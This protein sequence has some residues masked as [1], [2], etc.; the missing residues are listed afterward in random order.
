MLI[1]FSTALSDPKTDP[2]A[3]DHERFLGLISRNIWPIK[4]DFDCGESQPSVSSKFKDAR[5]RAH[6]ASQYAAVLVITNNGEWSEDIAPD[7][8][9][10]A[11]DKE[12]LLTEN[13]LHKVTALVGFDAAQQ[14]KNAA[15]GPEE[16]AFD[17][18]D[19][20]LTYAQARLNE[21]WETRFEEDI[22][23][24]THSTL[25]LSEMQA[26]VEKEGRVPFREERPDLDE[27]CREQRA[28]KRAG[29]LPPEVQTALEAL[30]GWRWVFPYND[31]NY[32]GNQ[33]H[34]AFKNLCLESKTTLLP[35]TTT[36]EDGTNV[37]VWLA[38]RRQ[39]YHA[40]RVPTPT[41]AMLETLPQWTWDHDEWCDRVAF[42]ELRDVLASGSVI[43]D[44][45]GQGLFTLRA[46]KRVL[47]WMHGKH[48]S[49]GLQPLRD[50]PGWRWGDPSS[51]DDLIEK[52]VLATALSRLK[53]SARQML[54]AAKRLV[55]P[56]ENTL[57]DIGKNAGTSREAIRQAE[58]RLLSALQHPHILHRVINT[59]KDLSIDV[60]DI[61]ALR[62]EPDCS[63][64]VTALRAEA[65]P[66]QHYA[67]TVLSRLYG[68]PIS[69]AETHRTR[70]SFS[71][72]EIQETQGTSASKL[73]DLHGTTRA[74]N[75]LISHGIETLEDM[76]ALDMLEVSSWH[77]IG[78]QSVEAIK[79]MR[80][81]A[82]AALGLEETQET[83][84][85][86]FTDL[87]GTTR[88][89]NA[90]ISHGI[91]TLEDMAALDMLEASSWRNIGIQSV[92]SIESMREQARTALALREAQEV[93][94][95][96]PDE[97]TDQHVTTT[98]INSPISHDVDSLE[99]HFSL[100]PET[101]GSDTHGMQTITMW[102]PELSPI[103][104]PTHRPES[105][106]HVSSSTVSPGVT[107]YVGLV[108]VSA[109]ATNLPNTPN[110]R[111]AN[112]KTQV[113]KDV[114]VSLRKNDG[115]FHLKNKGITMLATSVS[116]S[117]DGWE[118][119]LTPSVTQDS[120]GI[121]DGGHTYAVIC[122]ARKDNVRLDKQY[123]FVYVRTNVPIEGNL[124]AQIAEALNKT[125][126][127]SAGSL[128]NRLGEFDWIKV[129]LSTSGCAVAW[130]QND[131]GVKVEE[132]VARLYACN[133]KVLDHHKSYS[134][135]ASTLS[136]YRKDSTIL[137]SHRNAV[138]DILWLY[139]QIVFSLAEQ[140]EALL[141]KRAITSS[142][143]QS[144]LMDDSYARNKSRLV[145]GIA[146]PILSSFRACLINTDNG[147]HFN[148]D[149]NALA[150]L[151]RVQSGVL[152]A[153]IAE[154]WIE[155][156]KDPGALG[157]REA[158]WHDLYE[159]MQK[160]PPSPTSHVITQLVPQP[161]H[162]PFDELVSSED[163]STEWEAQLEERESYLQTLFDEYKSSTGTQV[164]KQLDETI[165]IVKSEIESLR[166]AIELTQGPDF[167]YCFR[168]GCGNKV[169]LP[170]ITDP[171]LCK[172]CVSCSDS[173]A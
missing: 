116:R 7:W 112:I 77:Y 97:M 129:A 67:E 86:D 11:L 160:V 23:S 4:S 18:T 89:I 42:V 149:R 144:P 125:T 128:L 40:G 24:A 80:E 49:F 94:D 12:V 33:R 47:D 48:P 53:L 50:L 5:E 130:R 35:F 153:K 63:S 138:T 165:G 110:L 159:I 22:E 31:N 69:L 83:Q 52:V 45:V 151:L 143:N 85:S 146:L 38:D 115:N 62:R 44:C 166:E 118:V 133:A 122:D 152:L 119:I 6:R 121:L 60:N 162:A 169:G 104:D 145:G 101:L 59:F 117:N 37:C 26:F 9:Q 168:I 41:A 120:D 17:V 111:A 113:A 73:S 81:Q 140:A 61:Q 163:L 21:Y 108:P 71:S 124:R 156:G 95:T 98:A 109:I 20:E 36:F 32:L 75:A 147:W 150:S 2:M 139:E 114:A 170:R 131:S 54:V 155:V 142:G 16:K 148:K 82:R 14:V 173:H 30:H 19:G 106:P 29:L 74:I 96:S 72:R 79:S 51:V 141:G 39:L 43:D 34:V 65:K 3:W 105:D 161:A 70:T 171:S 158:V 13:M 15:V 1:D 28:L 154:H 25:C 132:L 172:W 76:A 123:V 107:H 66:T 87:R 64:V 84:V 136:A 103:K 68:K 8:L 58:M 157:K 134:S 55:T 78:V 99:D 10:S 164:A 91:E 92:E 100:S 57:E 167:G 88:A 56:E 46:E 126:A 127:V 135:R 137:T 93:Q 102:V 90:L 27:W